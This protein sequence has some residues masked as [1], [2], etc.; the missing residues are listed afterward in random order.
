MPPVKFLDFEKAVKEWAW[1]EYADTENKKQKKLRGKE[2]KNPG[3]YVGM[4]IDWSEVKFTDDTR[5][6]RLESI[7]F[8]E[9]ENKAEGGK[10]QE[11]LDGLKADDSLRP[12]HGAIHASIL[13]QT[14]F[15]NNTGD[16][17]EYTMKTEKTTTSTC[18]T[19]IEN[20]WTKT[21]EM[22][23][24]LKTPCEVFEANAGY[25]REVSLS[26]TDGETFE[27]SLSWGVESQIK[28]KSNHIAEAQLVVNEKKYSGDFVVTTVVQGMV[29]ISFTDVRDNNS[30]LKA[31][32]HEMVNIIKWFL[33]R[34]RR[35][36]RTYEFVQTDEENEIVTVTTKGRC[37][38]RFG[39]KQEV[40]VHQK[41]INK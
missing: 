14:K 38:F 20:G 25:S 11:N 6:P 13:F 39:I 27:E 22:G 36:G 35:K 30:I 21:W 2:E 28:V 7:N 5:W 15:T 33:D 29:Y 41:K 12:D 9:N 31:T 37:K 3:M 24:N 4:H 23:I 32:G 19:E 1:H 8:D 40:V 18:S 16:D 34:E 17:Q 26:K 10:V